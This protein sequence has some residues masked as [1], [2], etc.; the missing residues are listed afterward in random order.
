MIGFQSIRQLNENT[1]VLEW[2]ENIG[3]DILSEILH[4]EQAIIKSHGDLINETYHS[5]HALAIQFHRDQTTFENLKK[6]ISHL[7]L[8][9]GTNLTPA[10]WEL[11][12]CYDG[13]FGTDLEEMSKRIGLAKEEIIKI[14]SESTYTLYFYGFL[15]GFMYLGGLDKRLYLNR[16][17]TPDRS[18]KSGSVA[19]GGTQT[20]IYPMD[21]PGGWHVIGK[22]P[23][24][25]YNT[26]KSPPC[27]M[28]P[29]DK[30]LFRPISIK[31]LE[32]INNQIE[33]GFYELNPN[34]N[35]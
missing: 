19:I 23:V 3:P 9:F 34:K 13:K 4:F 2:P 32:Q 15:P 12:V 16:K 7:N 17:S 21:S 5:Y 35:G 25:I 27:K 26:T 24:S 6:R 28:E 11:P 10:T 20:G 1:L 33:Q 14:H 8:D 29:G 22:C 18:V 31:E 30:I